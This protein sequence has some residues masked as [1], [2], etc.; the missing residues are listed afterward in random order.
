MKRKRLCRTAYWWKLSAAPA[1]LTTVQARD[2]PHSD[3][4]TMRVGKQGS[5]L[6]VDL[7]QDRLHIVHALFERKDL[8]ATIRH[9]VPRLSNRMTRQNDARTKIGF[10]PA[11]AR[12]PR[13]L[14]QSRAR[15][16]VRTSP[17]PGPDRTGNQPVVR[18]PSRVPAFERRSAHVA[19]EAV[20][21]A[22]FSH[23]LG[24][25]INRP[26]SAGPVKRF[27]HAATCASDRSITSYITRDR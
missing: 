19:L 15:T 10:D 12:W 7:A 8:G 17:R 6:G 14:T 24:A 9:S 27:S 2:D 25:A 18:D 22:T 21:L 26:A 4:L 1:Q 23:G 13:H 11:I 20:D 16:S 3:H 5:T